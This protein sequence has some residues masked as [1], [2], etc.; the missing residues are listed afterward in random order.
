MNYEMLE[1]FCLVEWVFS[2]TVEAKLK[3]RTKK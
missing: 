2:C 3:Q 1:K